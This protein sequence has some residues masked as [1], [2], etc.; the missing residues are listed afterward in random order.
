MVWSTEP[1][2]TVRSGVVSGSLNASDDVTDTRTITHFA[3]RRLHNEEVHDCV[4]L[5]H[6]QPD[7]NRIDCGFYVASMLEQLMANDMLREFD[8]VAFR[9]HLAHIVNAERGTFVLPPSLAV[10]RDYEQFARAAFPEDSAEIDEVKQ[11]NETTPLRAT[12][13]ASE[14]QVD[15]SMVEQAQS[16]DSF[17]ARIEEKAKT[18]IELG[19]YAGLTKMTYGLLRLFQNVGYRTEYI[20]TIAA[21]ER[22]GDSDLDEDLENEDQKYKASEELQKWL[23]TPA[24]WVHYKYDEGRRRITRETTTTYRNSKIWGKDVQERILA[25]EDLAPHLRETYQ[26]VESRPMHHKGEGV[27]CSSFPFASVM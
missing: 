22:D 4:F 11:D 20:T 8:I 19:T 27:P 17:V 9:Q 2:S 24:E 15:A 25:T 21:A 14:Q 13:I 6:Q 26:D 5:D 7:K 10:K 23:Y 1:F 16:F 18:L 3:P 12:S